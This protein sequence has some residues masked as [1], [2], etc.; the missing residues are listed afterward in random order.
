MV[1]AIMV[2]ATVYTFGKTSA[3]LSDVQARLDQ[4]EQGGVVGAT[5]TTSAAISFTAKI[6]QLKSDIA[7][8]AALIAAQAELISSLQEASAMHANVRS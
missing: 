7:D 1:A 6:K 5:G 8:Q 3:E 4:L 2:G